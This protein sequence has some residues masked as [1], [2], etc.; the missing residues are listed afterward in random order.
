MW[1]TLTLAWRCREAFSLRGSHSERL[2]GPGPSPPRPHIKGASQPQHPPLLKFLWHE[3]RGFPG[4][5]RGGGRDQTG[6]SQALLVGRI[7]SCSAGPPR[8]PGAAKHSWP[9]PLQLPLGMALPLLPEPRARTANPRRHSV[10]LTAACPPPWVSRTNCCHLFAAEEPRLLLLP[11]PRGTVAEAAVTPLGMP[12]GF[13]GC[14][15]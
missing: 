6:A 4:E 11:P 10:L 15:E 5:K 14:T 7:L 2:Q 13:S 3:R 12:S 8:P 1:D 9:G